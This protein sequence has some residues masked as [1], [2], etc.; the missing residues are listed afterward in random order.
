MG[1]VAGCTA[2]DLH[3]FM[4][5][6]EGSSLVRVTRE[7]HRILRGRGADL[8]GRN[9]SV[10]VVTVTALDESFVHPVM[11]RHLELGL[12]IQVAGIAKRW[13]SF[14]EQKFLGLRMVRRM[15]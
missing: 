9:G 6:H 2:F 8:L 14:D 15:A 5:K 12:L 11:E 4:L 7:T 10:R 3:G 13:L 1:R